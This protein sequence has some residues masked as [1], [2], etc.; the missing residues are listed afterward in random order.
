MT[1]APL[2]R[3]VRLASAAYRRLTLGRVP[4]LFDA[5]YYEAAAPEVARSGIDPYLHYVR[6]GAAQ[7]RDPAPDFDTAFYRRQSGP[8]RLD[9][10][11]HYLRV[12]AQAGLDPHPS[13]ST[14]CTWRA[15]PMSG[16]SG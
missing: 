14:R 1:L 6:R 15:T 10:L 5:A 12:G 7:D 13:F 16:P 2:A 3:A 4:R 8:T 11:R 9:P